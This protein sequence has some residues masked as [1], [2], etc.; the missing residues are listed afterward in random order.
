MDFALAFV[1]IALAA[2]AAWGALGALG[3]RIFV[4][5]GAYAP[6]DGLLVACCI[7][8]AL[9]LL[10]ALGDM[11]ERRRSAGNRSWR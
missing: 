5:N 9:A 11:R 7:Y 2:F 1:A 3:Y 8:G 4:D 6:D 10:V